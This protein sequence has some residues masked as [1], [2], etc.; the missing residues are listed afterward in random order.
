[1]KYQWPSSILQIIKHSK[2]GCYCN[3]LGNTRIQK[4]L[5]INT[6]DSRESYLKE[7]VQEKKVIHKGIFNAALLIMIRTLEQQ[8]LPITEMHSKLWHVNSMEYKIVS[9]M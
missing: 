3:S 9:T 2:I 5:N 6:F 1:M 8:S 7:I 4:A